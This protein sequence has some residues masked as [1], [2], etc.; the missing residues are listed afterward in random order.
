MKKLSV[1]KKL[2]VTA[3]LSIFSLIS[4]DNDDQEGSPVLGTWKATKTMTISGNNGV[5]LL[6]NPVT[7]CGAG[8]TYEFRANGDFEY[9]SSCTNSWETGTFQYSEGSMAITFYINVDG[10]DNEVGTET[11]YS[12]TS[13]EMQTITGKSD[14]DNDGMQDTSVIVYTKQ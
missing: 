3:G 12:L 9:R 7:G 6:Q 11:L 2:S 5:I 8:A 10:G 14:Y 1:I 4:C 13:S